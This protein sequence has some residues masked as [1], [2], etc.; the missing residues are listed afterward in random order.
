MPTPQ[1]FIEKGYVYFGYFPPEMES[2][3]LYPHYIKEEVEDTVQK[4]KSYQNENTVTFGFMTDLHYAPTNDHDICLSRT[5][6]A[7]KEIAKQ[8]GCDTLLLGGDLGAN[9]NKQF[10]TEAFVRFHKHFDGVRHFPITGN[11]DDNTIWQKCIDSPT[12]DHHFTHKELYELLFSHLPK[13]GVKTG[14]EDILYYYVDDAENKM[15]YICLDISDIPFIMEEGN[16]KYR[17]QN[18]FV[19]SQKQVEWL[20]KTALDFKEDGWGAV[21]VSHSAL[22]KNTRLKAEEYESNYLDVVNETINAFVG[23]KKVQKE[24]FDG[25]FRIKLDADFTNAKSQIYAVVL[26][27]FHDD[28]IVNETVPYI[29]TANSSMYN[30]QFYK[31]NQG[32]KTELL[33]DFITIDKAKRKIYI[34]R[35]GQGEDRETNY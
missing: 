15:R 32:D 3:E 16:L 18:T 9:G 31:R 19:L 8:V 30:S 20:T 34:T 4:I 14:G 11:H 7:Y 28:I 5:V 1:E 25:D 22:C 17:G 12:S 29:A 27:H 21:I 2:E 26:G 6:N 24:M 23:R 13:Y 33:F 10:A 35:V